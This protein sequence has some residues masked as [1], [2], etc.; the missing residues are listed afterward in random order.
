MSNVKIDWAPILEGYIQYLEKKYSD[1]PVRPSF[2]SIIDELNN[3]KVKSRVI[4]KGIEVAAYAYIIESRE[5]SDRMFGSV[6][7][8]DSKYC[9]DDRLNNLMHWILDEA[10]KINKF[11]MMDE[12]F[13]CNEKS[14]ITLKQLGFKKITRNRM[15][16]RIGNF[17]KEKAEISSDLLSSGLRGINVND[18]ARAQYEAYSDSDDAIL[19]SGVSEAERTRV[20]ESILAGRYGRVIAD[21]SKVLRKDGKIVGAILV[22]D[23]RTHGRREDD[24]MIVDIFVSKEYRRKGIGYHLLS[25]AIDSL[26]HKG[27][28]NVH[29]WVS[30]SNEASVFYGKSGFV[31]SDYPQEVFYYKKD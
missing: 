9:T 23:G 19:F 20:V 25:A 17:T 31:K 6:G 15:D 10:R 1:I 30:S 2:S 28:S 3:N 7:F 13:N 5:E 8:T 12:I 24:P 11:V 22:T 16:L 14:G 21:A 26:K 18:Y 29:L 27:Y 4:L